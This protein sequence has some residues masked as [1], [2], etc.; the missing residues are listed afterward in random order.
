MVHIDVIFHS[1]LVWSP[2][3]GYFQSSY[4]LTSQFFFCL[5]Y[6]VVDSLSC[7]FFISLIEFFSCRIFLNFFSLLDFFCVHAL[8]SSFCCIVYVFSY[9]SLSFLKPAIFIFYHSLS[10]STVIRRQLWSFHDVMSP[11]IFMFLGVLDCCLHIWGNSH[12]LQS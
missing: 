6:Y 3:I 2:T 7:T 11:W 5:I 9:S 10:L 12:F 8:F 4:I 1:F